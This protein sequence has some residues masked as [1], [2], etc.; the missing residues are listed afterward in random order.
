MMSAAYAQQPVWRPE[1]PVE[2]VVAVSA[3]GAT[4]KTA[5]FIQSIVQQHRIIDSPVVLVNRPG[6]GGNLALNYLDQRPATR[7]TFST[8]R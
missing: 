3:G 7:I 8:R 2:L 6:G 1:R 5:R 4:D